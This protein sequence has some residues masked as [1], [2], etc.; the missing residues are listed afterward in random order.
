MMSR[1]SMLPG[2]RLHAFPSHMVVLAAT[3]FATLVAYTTPTF[4]GG[5]TIPES[6]TLSAA[7]GGTGV[8][9][10]R[11]PS[12]LYF[13]PALL[14][15]LGGFQT[16][17][18]VN[19]VDLNVRFQR[20]DLVV[21]PNDERTTFDPVTQQRGPLPVPALGFTWS[22]DIDNL[23]VGAGIFAPNAYG[24]RCYGELEGSDCNVDRDG[25]A[26][27]MLVSS[28][29]IEA[30]AMAGAGYRFPDLLPGKLSLGASIMAA[31][32]EADFSLVANAWPFPSSPWRE[33]PDREAVFRG[34]KMT[35]IVPSGI[36]GAAYTHDHFTIG[37]SYRPPFSWDA[38]GEADVDFPDNIENSFGPRLTDDAINFRSNQAGVLRAGASYESPRHIGTPSRSA[39]SLETNVV[40]ENWS[41]V[42]S[43]EL[44]PQ[45]DI[46]FENIDNDA[47]QGE[48]LQPIFQPKGYNDTFS[49]RLGGGYS[50]TP[51]LTLHGGSYLE[52]PAQPKAWTNVD[53]VSWERYAGSVGTTLHLHEFTGL[54]KEVELK[55]AYSYI[56]SPDRTVTDGN[57]YNQVPL[58][59]C[60]GPDYDDDTCEDPGTPPGNPQNNGE[61][62]TFTQV[63]SVGLTWRY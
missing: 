38:T 20:D 59:Q 32:L 54:G 21:G 3:V 31:Y 13:N 40:W 56:G 61:W 51:W 22:P 17:V 33:N 58:S 30:F 55:L 63:G 57:V 23:T 43:F 26:R 39:W 16:L 14:P 2:C 6:T 60:T 29:L 28:R 15:R 27:H 53:F 62:S 24:E 41:I 18:D 4:A 12:A 34:K 5:F 48:L 37:V 46:E 25:A 9:G 50:P 42:D 7:R 45:G 11:D 49:L 47:T 52:T 44:A 10:K 36:L 35:D 1:S 8:A 19:A